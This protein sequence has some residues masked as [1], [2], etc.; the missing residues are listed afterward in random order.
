MTSCNN[1]C[2]GRRRKV[3]LIVGCNI[4]LPPKVKRNV[5]SDNRWCI[6]PSPTLHFNNQSFR[7]LRL[8][9]NKAPGRVEDDWTRN[10]A[11]WRVGQSI[12]QWGNVLISKYDKLSHILARSHNRGFIMIQVSSRLVRIFT[13]WLQHIKAI[14]K[15]SVFSSS[16]AV[17]MQLLISVSYLSSSSVGWPT[18]PFPKAWSH[19]VLFRS[20]LRETRRPHFTFFLL[21]ITNRDLYKVKIFFGREFRDG[22]WRRTSWFSMKL[23]MG[24]PLDSIDTISSATHDVD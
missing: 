13:F 4:A 14:R 2:Q 11:P 22:G 15:S 16:G 23:S 3:F 18:E 10:C 24:L 12:S 8:T 9:S 7:N 20:L 6:N 17:A 5:I 1:F 21:F 19:F